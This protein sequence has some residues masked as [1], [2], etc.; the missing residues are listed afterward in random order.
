[1]KIIPD[2]VKNDLCLRFGGTPES[3]CFLG[4]GQDWSDGVVFTFTPAVPEAPRSKVLK[5]IEFKPDDAEGL[6]RAR[7]KVRLVRTFGEQGARLAFPEP[8]PEGSLFET[9]EEGG[10]VFMAYVCVKVSGRPLEKKDRLA[11]SSAYYRALGS[12]LGRLHTVSEARPETLASDGTSRGKSGWTGSISFFISGGACCSCLSRTR[13]SNI[14]PGANA[15]SGVLSRKTNGSL[16]SAEIY[17]VVVNIVVRY[18]R[19]R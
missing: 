16:A 3:L 7:D 10:R 9:L 8:S 11:H 13:W 2:P 5:I 17:Q 1:V 15:G 12:L 14:R 19:S 4:G 6:A 18:T